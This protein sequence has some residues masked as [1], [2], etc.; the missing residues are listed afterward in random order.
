[1]P[2]IN[3]IRDRLIAFQLDNGPIGTVGRTAP[4]I[5]RLVSAICQSLGR[6]IPTSL[7]PVTLLADASVTSAQTLFSLRNQI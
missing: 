7:T 2:R 6:G 1:M 5:T 4:T 3:G